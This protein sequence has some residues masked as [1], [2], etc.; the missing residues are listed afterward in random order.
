MI[1]TLEVHIEE[2]AKQESM[3]FK[4]VIARCV[5]TA[6]IMYLV[7]TQSG[8]YE[9]MFDEAVLSKIQDILIADA[10]STPAFR[11]VYGFFFVELYQKRYMGSKARTQEELN[12]LYKPMDWNL[13]ERYTDVMK[14]C[15]V[16][17]FFSA[18]L[19][20]ALFITSLAMF[21]AYLRWVVGS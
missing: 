18:I 11:L 2:G 1:T 21:T 14:T 5:N 20:S 3:L 12:F 9:D 8:S 10:F 15:F 16:G 6:L 13:A 4:L 7:Q 19:P 17:L